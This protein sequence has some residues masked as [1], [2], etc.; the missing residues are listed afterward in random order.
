[1]AFGSGAHYCGGDLALRLTNSVLGRWSSF[2][3]F[4]VGVI[5]IV[6][7]VIGFT[8]Y[9]LPAPIVD[10]LLAIMEILTLIAALIMLVMMAA[11][12]GRAPDNRKMVGAIAFAFMILMTGMTRIVHFVE[13]TAMRQFGTVSLVWP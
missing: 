8:T 11:I 4:L 2:A 5:Y 12:Y 7:L 9:G 3:V 1:M 6:A 10:P 13:L